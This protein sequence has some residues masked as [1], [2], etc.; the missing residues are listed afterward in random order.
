LVVLIIDEHDDISAIRKLTE[1]HGLI[2]DCQALDFRDE[3]MILAAYPNTDRKRCRVLRHGSR[4]MP[5]TAEEIET[6]K[7]EARIQLLISCIFTAICLFSFIRLCRRNRRMS[8][9]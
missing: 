8:V 5:I 2:E 9:Q 1:V 4:Q 3:Q 7:T 6:R